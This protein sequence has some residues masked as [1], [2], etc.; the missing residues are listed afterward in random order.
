MILLNKYY[1]ETEEHLDFYG[2]FELSKCAPKYKF[3]KFI[4]YIK[5]LAKYLA[6][7]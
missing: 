3:N 6:E 1:Q 4:K 7:K 2:N 5:Y